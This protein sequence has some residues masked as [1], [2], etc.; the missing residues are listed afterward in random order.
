MP[1]RF[2]IEALHVIRRERR[3]QTYDPIAAS[4]AHIKVADAHVQTVFIRSVEIEEAI[5]FQHSQY[6]FQSMKRFVQVFD[7]SVHDHCVE[8]IISE[9]HLLKRA[10][11]RLN[12]KMIALPPDIFRRGIDPDAIPTGFARSPQNLAAAAANVQNLSS[13][14]QPRFDCRNQ[15]LTAAL[16]LFQVMQLE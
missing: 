11:S 16:L 9:L 14:L 2:R 8:R 13:S 12:P 7:H 1:D 3:R 15:S 10:L 5:W 4:G 6:L